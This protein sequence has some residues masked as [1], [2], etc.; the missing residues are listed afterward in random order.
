MEAIRYYFKGNKMVKI[1]A[2]S[3]YV[4]PNGKL[5]G[6]KAIIKIKEFSAIPD[7]TY[8]NLPTGVK[9]VTKKPKTVKK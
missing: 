5:D 2:A 6:N 1:A 3:Y 4:L 8:L 9:D 7:A